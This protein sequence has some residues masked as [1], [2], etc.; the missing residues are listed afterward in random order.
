MYIA[1]F[2][3]PFD[4]ISYDVA[5]DSGDGQAFSH[6]LIYRG[7]PVQAYEGGE[8]QKEPS[9]QGQTRQTT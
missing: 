7:R 9:T 3:I 2:R 8:T 5:F 4:L 1:Q 6:R